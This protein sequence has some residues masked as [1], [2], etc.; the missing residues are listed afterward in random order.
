MKPGRNEPCLCG[1][2]KKYKKCCIDKVIINDKEMEQ[3][4][5]KQ[6]SLMKNL[7]IQNC[8]QIIVDGNKII[9]AN[10]PY[11]FISGTFTNM[12]RAYWCLWKEI[13]SNDDLKNARELCDKALDLKPENQQALIISYDIYIE[14]LEFSQAAQALKSVKDMSILKKAEQQIVMSYQHAIDCANS[15]DFN[16]ESQKGLSEI[17]DYLFEK[18][19]K[20]AGLCGVATS[21][22]IGIGNDTLRAYELAKCC[23]EQWPNPEVYCTLGL[24]SLYPEINRITESIDYLT[25]ALEL[26]KDDILTFGIKSNLVISLMQNKQYDKAYDLVNQLI[27]LNPNNQNYSNYAELLKRKGNYK[28]AIQW[29]KKA[30]FLV[31]DDTTLLV[32]ADIYKKNKGFE[33]A[34]ETYIACLNSIQ[35]NENTYAF[36]D[37]YGSL[38]HSLASN[39]AMG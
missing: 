29:C 32:L 23:V 16:E 10:K 35:Y 1:S 39:S 33:L 27:K 24:I 4:Y 17:T 7:T 28:E 12:A 8:H 5:L 30:L 20:N 38:M 9:S 26:S 18:Y 13:N 6:Y 2:G 34:V 25:K 3:L 22:Y 14:I 19:G 21:F 15:T 36:L 11:K 31:E 37:E